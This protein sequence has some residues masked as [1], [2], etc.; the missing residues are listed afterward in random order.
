MIWIAVIIPILGA[1]VMLKWFR[2]HLAWWEV[3]VPMGV[4]LIFTL[5]FKFTVEQI[6]TTDTEYKGALVLEARY[7][8]YW[9]TYVRKT[10]S[11]TTKVGKTTI[12]TYYDCSYC[13]ENPPHWSVVDSRGN[14][15][16]ISQSYYNSLMKR[17]KSSEEFVELNRDINTGGW[18]CGKDGDMYRI[19]WNG[20]PVTSDAT[21]T[22]NWYE[23]R[24]QAAHTVFDFPEVTEEDKKTYHLVD[25]PEIKG[26]MQSTVLG[27]TVKWMSKAERS[28]GEKLIQHSCGY[29]G[30]KKHANIW[31]IFFVDKPTMSAT[32]QEAYWDGGNDNEVTICIGIDS[33]TRELQWVKPFSWTPNRTLLVNLRED[34]M[35]TKNFDFD[36]IKQAIDKNM[37]TYQR[38]DFKEFNYITVDPP[39]W[40]VVTTFIVTI[41]STVGLCWWAVANNYIADDNNLWRTIEKNTWGRWR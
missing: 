31:M 29:W 19:T 9:E 16:S 7:Y 38:K 4:A 21:V 40:A 5:I 24:V 26:Y 3:L 41:L 14:E 11:R 32:M 6:Q 18:G 1:F 28:R 22:S 30:P 17:W 23:N 2:E 39:T 8:E 25:Y 13:D 33:K 35:N 15:Y 10:C 37:P 12:T 27:D 36:K 34:I 20:D